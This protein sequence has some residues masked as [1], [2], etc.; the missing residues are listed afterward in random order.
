VRH[1]TVGDAQRA[2]L[3][4]V[5]ENTRSAQGP[6][7]LFEFISGEDDEFA[8]LNAFE[9]S[10]HKGVAEGAGA[11]GYENAFVVDH[12]GNHQARMVLVLMGNA[13][14]VSTTQGIH[15]VSWV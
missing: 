13:L 8:G 9:A 7:V 11:A 6:F 10:P 5:V 14:R 12:F 15:S 3:R 4:G 1:A 2:F